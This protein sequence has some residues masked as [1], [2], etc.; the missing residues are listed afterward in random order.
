MPRAQRVFEL[1]ELVRGREEVTVPEIAACLG[2]SERSVFRDL[3]LL[4]ELGFP[5]RGEGGPG[6]GVRLERE[7]GVS[8]V[9]LRDDE[10]VALWLSA[11]LSRMA[12]ALPWGRAARSGLD[13][14]FASVPRA[15]ARQL[16]ALCQRVVVGAPASAAVRSGAAEPPPE[17]LGKF[18]RAFTTGV[19]LAFD[20]RDRHGRVSSRHVEP[21]GL[22]V[23]PPVWYVLA[24]DLDRAAPR[25]FRMDRIRRPSLLESRPFQPNPRLVR[26]L[27]AH[28]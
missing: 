17:L 21:H 22:L 27:T 28:V 7:R 23:E 16:R 11:H 6:G 2:V 4:R 10:V 26:E 9:H 18:E 25:T 13:K 12:T 15:R 5:I 19:C 24:Y 20:Y 14:L 8:A 3:S 1:L